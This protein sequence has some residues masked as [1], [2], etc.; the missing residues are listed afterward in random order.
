[1]SVQDKMKALVLESYNTNLVRALYGVKMMEIPVPGIAENQV[2]IK[3]EA[4]PVNPSDIAFLRGGYNIQKTLPAV[5]GFE[6]AGRIVSVGSG[7]DKNLTGKM[8]CF[9]TQDENVGSWAEYATVN[10]AN[11]IILHEEVPI[12]QAACMFVN[13][14]TAYALFEHVTENGHEAL[15]LTGAGGQVGQ[16]VRFF[17]KERGIKI[18]NLVRK[19][20]HIAELQ[21][22]GEECVLNVLDKDFNL[23]LLE[24]ASQ[25]NA[26]AAIDAVGGELTGKLLNVMPEGSEIVL[27]GGLSGQPVSGID[28]LEIIFKNKIVG[29]FNLGAWLK[30]IPS[31]ELLVISEYLQHLILEKKIETK[32][33][34]IFPLQDFYIGL[35]SYI[36]NMSGGKV[37]LKM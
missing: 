25:L 26:T 14:F 33:Q 19:E 13:P 21:N 6:G 9:F 31:E 11:T 16:F 5:P 3:I 37:L 30:D 20:Q 12:E 18:I 29:G 34:A 35:R 15:I 27:Y 28:P 23:Y 2:L 32:V 24:T 1:M 36:S 22:Q 17:A 10:V 4:A 8:V 7:V